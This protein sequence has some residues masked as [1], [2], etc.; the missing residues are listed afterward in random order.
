MTTEDTNELASRVELARNG[1]P[2][3][4]GWLYERFSDR[5]YSYAY[6]KLGDPTEAEDVAEQVFLKVIERID[7]FTWQGSGFP[8]WLFRI[9]QNQVIDSLRGRSRHRQVPIEEAGEL[10]SPESADP[11]HYAERSDFLDHLRPAIAQLTDLQAQ[12]ISLKYAAGLRNAE[13]AE[14]MS[15]SANSVNALHYEALKKL[16]RLL[17]REGYIP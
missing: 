15:R 13:I 3:A 10:T 6:L 7:R 16:E 9:A 4:I 14:V 1:D 5:V 12:V 8:A 11:Q 17:T 2:E